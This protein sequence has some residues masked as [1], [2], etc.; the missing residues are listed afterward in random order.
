MRFEVTRLAQHLKVLGIVRS[1]ATMQ[2]SA[3]MHFEPPSTPTALATPV[4]RLQR[5]FPGKRPTW[6]GELG[7]VT[8]HGITVGPWPNTTW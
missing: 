5:L 7:V 2:R 3:V 1:A 4:C 8:T 6:P